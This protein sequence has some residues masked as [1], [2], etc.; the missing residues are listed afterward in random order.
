MDSVSVERLVTPPHTRTPLRLPDHYSRLRRR[1]GGR[2]TRKRMLSE[3]A[4]AK[5]RQTDA[6]RYTTGVKLPLRTPPTPDHLR[7]LP[8]P[9]H[10][11]HINYE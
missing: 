5:R 6:R 2:R 11:R 4:G 10:I 8:P 9:L 3:K 7:L 1:A